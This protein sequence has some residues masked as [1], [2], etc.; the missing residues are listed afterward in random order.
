MSVQNFILLNSTIKGLNDCAFIST[1]EVLSYLDIDFAS[2][3]APCE[4]SYDKLYKDENGYF[5]NF[6]SILDSAKENNSCIVT[7]EDSSHMGLCK[8]NEYF[9]LNVNIINAYELIKDRMFDFTFS[10]SL[11]EYNC[12]LFD[13]FCIDAQIK[14]K[15]SVLNSLSLHVKT[16]KFHNDGFSFLDF[17]K[18]FAYKMA[19]DVLLDA[20]DSGCDFVVV[21]DIRSFHMFDTMQNRL[22]SAVGREFGKSGIAILTL[23]ELLLIALGKADFK[24]I[25]K[26]NIKPSLID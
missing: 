4:M 18:E 17:D 20:F 16:S 5:A 21:N 11:K 22:S 25:Y 10:N 13:T 12:Y 26:H 9:N 8:A 2:I 14:S 3:D 1:K 23:S 24:K 19:G 7:L 15:L 6:K